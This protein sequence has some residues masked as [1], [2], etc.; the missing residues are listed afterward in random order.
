MGYGRRRALAAHAGWVLS[1]AGPWQVESSLGS[2]A[3]CAEAAVVGFPHDI[4]VRARVT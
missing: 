1:L 2:H 3:A 4:K